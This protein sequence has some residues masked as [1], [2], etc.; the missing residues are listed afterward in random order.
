MKRS[1]KVAC[2]IGMAG[3]ALAG[4]AQVYTFDS[5]L[6]TGYTDGSIPQDGSMLYLHINTED[7]DNTMAGTVSSNSF[8]VY[9][10]IA[11]D[12]T[13][14]NG[15]LYLTLTAPVQSNGDVLTATLVNRPGVG[16]D[17]S[18][19]QGNGLNITLFDG[20]DPNNSSIKDIH[21]YQ[22][23]TVYVPGQQVTGIYRSDGRS[24]TTSD[25]NYELYN[26][27]ER[28]ATTTIFEGIN[29]NGNW[30]LA[31]ADLGAGSGAAI[32]KSW[33]LDFTPIPEPQQYAMVVGAGLMA[34]GF[35][36]NRMRKSA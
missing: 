32:I 24:L 2:M 26:S 6:G 21:W 35:Y 3:F 28:S 23:D 13:A 4:N 27:M 17:A 34:F 9:L 5:E 30:T 12:D 19:Y 33:G 14:V 18:G 10:N 8:R 20:T 1:L 15:D 7:N 25:Q 36:R 22:Q 11:G 16:L 29:P 31:V